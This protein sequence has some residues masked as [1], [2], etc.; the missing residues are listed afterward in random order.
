MQ[1]MYETFHH[2]VQS[3]GIPAERKIEVWGNKGR[4][5]TEQVVETG[6][7][8]SKDENEAVKNGVI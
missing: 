3:C 7:H 4:N 8:G 5:V 2:P 1:R 6:W